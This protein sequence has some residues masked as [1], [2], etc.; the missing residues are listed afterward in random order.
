SC[1][2]Y[3]KHRLRSESDE[4]LTSSTSELNG[5]RRKSRKLHYEIVSLRQHRASDFGNGVPAQPR[6]ERSGRRS[7]FVVG[8]V[9]MNGYFAVPYRWDRLMP[10][11]P[12]ITL[13]ALFALLAL[14]PAQA[15]E[16]SIVV[17]STTSPQ[18]SGLFGHILPLFKAKT[19]IDV[20]VTA[21]GTG[22]ALDI[23]R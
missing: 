6:Y 23:G 12:L 22:K 19:G 2:S 15:Q 9:W 10:I 1:R 3:R 20:R 21:V 13:S 5:A 11:R 16:K 14:S 18:D 4:C 17:T 8:H 7:G